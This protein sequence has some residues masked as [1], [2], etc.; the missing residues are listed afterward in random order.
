[1]KEITRSDAPAAL[2]YIA[3]ATGW[4]AIGAIAVG[5]IAV[6]TI[7]IGSMAIGRLAIKKVRL[8]TV[9]IDNLTVRRLHVL[10]SIT[11]AP[12]PAAAESVA[13]PGKNGEERA[14]PA[15]RRRRP[16]KPI[17]T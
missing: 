15:P 13:A 10:E 8:K 11:P 14:S 4:V 1:M 5:A 7:A 9:E 12:Q 3:T 6:G 2:S 17:P 16:R